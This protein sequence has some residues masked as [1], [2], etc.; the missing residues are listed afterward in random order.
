MQFIKKRPL[1][2]ISIFLFFLSLFIRYR[3]RGLTN[4]DTTIIEG[5][6][7]HIYKNGFAG[8]SDDSFSNYPPAYLYFLW[9]T[10][11]LSKWIG[12]L[13][14]IKIIPTAF[15]FVSSYAIFLI[16]RTKYKTDLPCLFAAVFFLL[17]TVVLNS[18]GWGQ[19][20][21]M[22]TSFLLIST[23]FLLKKNS[24]AALLAFGAAFSFK[25]QAV[26]FLPFLGIMF[27]RGLIRWYYFLLIPA[28][29]LL[30]AL[31]AALVGRSW[32]SII[33]LYA[34]QVGQF[35]ELAKTAPNLY[36]FI[37][38]IYYQPVMKIGLIIFFV[39]MS[40]WAWKNWRRHSTINEKQ[41]ILTALASLVIA[42]FLLPKMH[43]RYFYPA[44]LFSFAA[45][46]F[47][48]EVWFL[49]LLFQV[50]SGLSYTIFLFGMPPI[51]VKI[52]AL[53]NT[54]LIIYIVRKQIQSLRGDIPV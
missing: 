36:F 23:Y 16:A 45:V 20:D 51:L 7:E 53:I 43:D 38:N 44:D 2:L 25:A 17:P 22:Y 39:A 35:E 24:F 27:L 54:V 13:V 4:I 30:L 32:E 5:W 40:A 19:T 52:A 47:I 8:L 1:L 41:L 49:P 21:S 29:Y 48:P 12:P 3:I 18:T 42:P 26:F 11:L 10:T 46:I 50:S 15:D 6:Y 31:P 37:P 28:V 34:G 9:F 33:T 14:S